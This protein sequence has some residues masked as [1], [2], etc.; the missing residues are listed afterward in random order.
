VLRG[1]CPRKSILIPTAI[2]TNDTLHVGAA[3]DQR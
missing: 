1:T 2:V 3:A